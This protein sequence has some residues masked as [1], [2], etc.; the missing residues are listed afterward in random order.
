MET[1]DENG[2]PLSNVS[3]IDLVI[4]NP[5]GRP[6]QITIGSENGAIIYQNSFTQQVNNFHYMVEGF[7]ATYH[8]TMTLNDDT[9]GTAFYHKNISLPTM[10]TFTNSTVGNDSIDKIFVIY[11]YYVKSGTTPD[12]IET[13]K[14]IIYSGDGE[15]IVDECQLNQVST[16][17]DF[18]GN[19]SS[20][21]NLISLSI[22]GLNQG[23]YILRI[24][25]ALTG[26]YQTDVSF[27][28]STAPYSY[29][30][31]LYEE[32]ISIA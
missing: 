23:L 2:N 14:A 28:P 31:I 29:D 32:S 19:P 27:E 13:I 9:S 8:I 17:L 30:Y 6:Y 7:Y 20:N 15:T 21:G 25:S 11:N 5:K 4:N 18:S 26:A 24:T 22:A 16:H 1:I 12:Q 10:L 3:I